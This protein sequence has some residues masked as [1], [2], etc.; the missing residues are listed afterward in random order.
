MRVAIFGASGPTG[1]LLTR[2][3][4]HD[5]HTAVAITRRPDDFPFSAERL[6]VVGA[7]AATPGGVAEA[8]DGADAVVSVLGAPFS[9]RPIQLYSSSAQA[10]C[11]A[12]AQ[13]GARR[14]VVT[15]SAVLSGWTDPAWSWFD[16]TMAHHVVGRLGRTLY[17]DMRRMEAIV[18]ASDL[19]WTIMRPLGLANL[20]PPTVYRIAADHI[21]GRQ[22]A[23]S[24]LASAIADQLTRDDFHRQVAAVATVNKHQSLGE[25]IWRE[26]MKPNLPSWILRSRK[27]SMQLKVKPRE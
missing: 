8:I 10:F 13:T 23:R 24:D 21:P 26:G 9:R 27:A 6:Q 1:L 22:T 5:G 18:S 20:D 25:I 14:L 17:D 12:M 3:V 15:S 19:D 11:H 7:D 2:R 16:R 4:L